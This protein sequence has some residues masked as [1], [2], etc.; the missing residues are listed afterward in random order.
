MKIVDLAWTIPH[1]YCLRLVFLF[2]WC[3][4]YGQTVQAITV[5]IW[6][7]SLW[8]IL[9]KLQGIAHQHLTK[10]K[11]KCDIRMLVIPEGRTVDFIFTKKTI[12]RW[13]TFSNNSGT[14]GI[15]CFETWLYTSNLWYHCV[16]SLPLFAFWNIA[17]LQ[18]S[19]LQW[20]F[21]Q[22]TVLASG[23]GITIQ[24]YLSFPFTPG[25]IIVYFHLLLSIR[26][27]RFYALF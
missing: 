15:C 4:N 3:K 1:C 19:L 12:P 14:P 21:R 11:L 22:N 6:F 27:I 8:I 10:A 9:S 23:D 7:R 5:F 26:S 24:L 20:W 13:D 18:N 16:L 17:W 25:F 2:V